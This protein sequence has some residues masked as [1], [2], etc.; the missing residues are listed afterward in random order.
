M[1]SILK[2]QLGNQVNDKRKFS[3]FPITGVDKA[4]ACLK[5]LQLYLKFVYLTCNHSNIKV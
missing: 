5:Y 1:Y 4:L 3:I 2:N